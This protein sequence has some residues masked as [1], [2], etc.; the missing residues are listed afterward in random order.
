[1]ELR[2]GTRLES[3][4]CEAQFVVVRAPAATD[5]DLRC[6]GAPVQPLG[7]GAP[8]AGITVSGESV[9]IGKRYADEEV[10]LELL[11]TRAGEGALTLGEEPLFLMGAKPLPASD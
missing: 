4:A 3:A 2:P 8:R 1:M 6:G 7:T 9:Q 11:C 5:V 10:G